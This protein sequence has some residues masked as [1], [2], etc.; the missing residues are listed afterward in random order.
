MRRASQKRDAVARAQESVRKRH[1]QHVSDIRRAA[2]LIRTGQ[3]PR[4]E[5]ILMRHGPRPGQDDLREFAWFYLLRQCHS[6]RGTLS[7]HHGDVYHVEFSARGDLLASAGKDGTVL[8]WNTT[9][10]QLVRSI[11]AS[12]AE[13]N[14]AAFSPDGKTLATVDDEGK[15]KLWEL[16]S[17]RCE[18]AREAHKRDAVIA[19][20]TRDG[21]FVITGGR[22]DRFDRIWD[23]STGATQGEFPFPGHVLEAA[24]LS[25]DGS[26]LVM[27]GG[28]EVVFWDLNREVRAG[29]LKTGQEMLQGAAFSRD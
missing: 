12:D 3:G 16:A 13:V 23:R 5:E 6:E 10:W 20:F 14:A 8:I 2:H 25:P 26:T 21:K 11:K 4:A 15:L 29:S 19:L 27:V 22:N 17:G 24:A 1:L 7:G 28:S 9:S 18:L